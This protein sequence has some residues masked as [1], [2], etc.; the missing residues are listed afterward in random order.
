VRRLLLLSGLVYGLVFL[1]LVTLKGELLALA[2]PLVIYLGA[3]LFYGPEELRL[4]AT[5]TLSADRVAG[6]TPA[7]VKLAVTNEGSRLE[8]V[9]VE[10]LVPSPLELTDGE[11]RALVSLPPGETVALEY[12]L[13]GRRGSYEFQGAQVTASDQ[14]GLFRR[15]A[16]LPAPAHLTVLPEVLKLRRIMIRPLQ[17]HGYAGPVPARRGGSGVEFFGVREY[18]PGDP[19]RWINWRVSARHPRA[20]FTN[21]FEQERI[22]D[23]GLILDARQRSDVRSKGDSLF[24]HSV[25]ATASLAEVFINDGNRVGLLVYGGF[26]DWTFPGYGKVQRE[27]IL[28]ALA[29]AETGESLVFQSLD[30]LPTRFFPAK[31][32]L[33]MISPLC[34]DDLPMLIRLRA[35]GYQ[36]LV[37]SPDPIPFE[38]KTL[39]LGPDVALA[40]RIAR[41][42]RVLILRRLRQ[43]GIQIVDWQVDR[44][45]DQTVHSSLG[46]LPHWFRAVGVEL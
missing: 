17:T 4:R 23:V 45:F 10:D 27:R 3:A 2:V 28:R 42:E 25:R 39:G 26:L 20:L 24:E 9:L 21:E 22:A 6:G 40:T 13:S 1:G 35:R 34:K 11:S 7:V 31:S 14:L 30:Y 16:M 46:R 5:R 33:V 8:E 18:Q 37:I 15:Q 41:L 38:A 29:R 12:T 43:A 32:Q 19:R 36:L 44:P